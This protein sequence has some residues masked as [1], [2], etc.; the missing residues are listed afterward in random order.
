[1]KDIIIFLG[2]GASSAEGAPIQTNLF[3]EYFEMVRKKDIKIGMHYTKYFKKFWGIDVEND[4]LE[5]SLF[6]TFEEALGMLE[7]AKSRQEGFHGYQSTANNNKIDHTIENL[8]FLIVS[9]LKEK[10]IRGGNHH[11]ELVKNIIKNKLE[12]NVSFISLNYDILIDNAILKHIEIDLDYG[13]NFMNYQLNSNWNLP[14]KDKSVNLYKIHGSLNWLYC[15]VCKKI[16]ITHKRKGVSELIDKSYS[17]PSCKEKLVPILIPPTFFKIMSN[18]YLINIWD[19]AEEAL[20]NCDKIIF[21]GYSLPDADIHIKYLLKRGYLNRIKIPPKIIVV[22]NHS[23]KKDNIKKE[24]E[25]RY[26]RLFA[27]NVDYTDL[28]FEEFASNPC[29]IL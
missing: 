14:K 1:M 22:N 2:A 3:K 29:I 13:I 7:L 21:C 5:S 8:I 6:P 11:S 12:K 28:T 20:T 16:L 24:E 17:C 23:N 26:K 10:L 4:N 25:I 27:S 9:I 18:S 15:P 19:L